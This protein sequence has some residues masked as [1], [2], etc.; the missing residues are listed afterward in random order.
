MLTPFL[1]HIV[2]MDRWYVLII[3]TKRT[4]CWRLKDVG[5]IPIVNT[6]QLL[7]VSFGSWLPVI[8]TWFDSA[9]YHSGVMMFGW[10]W[11]FSDALCLQCFVNEAFLKNMP[12][13]SL[14]RHLKHSFIYMARALFIVTLNVKT[15]CWVGMAKWSLV[16]LVL[17]THGIQT[18]THFSLYNS[19]FWFGYTYQSS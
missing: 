8:A 7:Y 4:S 17:V 1:Y 12:F 15:C 18:M 14:A 16:S 13:I 3:G 10:P 2:L 5:L 6:D 11:I 9:K 19:W